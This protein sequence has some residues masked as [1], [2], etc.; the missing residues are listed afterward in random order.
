MLILSA[1]S[2]FSLLLPYHPVVP[3]MLI[4]GCLSFHALVLTYIS[5]IIL[6]KRPQDFPGS[7]VVKTPTSTVGGP[8]LI[9]DP[10]IKVMHAT[11]YNQKK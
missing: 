7:P 9:P 10:E 1:H 4:F 2:F 11:W 6:N 8:G 5:Q 3:F